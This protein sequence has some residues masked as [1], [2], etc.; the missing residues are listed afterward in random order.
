MI[1]H[2]GMDAFYASV[3][4]RDRPELVG[5]PVIV[6]GSPEKRGVMS[7]ANYV[8]RRY[9]VHSA[10]PSV[11]SR[12]GVRRDHPPTLPDIRPLAVQHDLVRV[13][14]PAEVVVHPRVVESHRQDVVHG[15]AVAADQ[16]DARLRADHRQHGQV[17]RVDRAAGIA[18]GFDAQDFG[19]LVAADPDAPTL[20][21][22]DED[23]GAAGRRGNPSSGLTQPGEP[24]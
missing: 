17:R 4:D 19:W 21:G 1:F 5:K 15:G 9:G 6:G 12:Y 13:Q 10:T 18:L 2:C 14:H 22:V 23:L 8:A 24:A 11:S 20:P 7:A 3:E 16:F